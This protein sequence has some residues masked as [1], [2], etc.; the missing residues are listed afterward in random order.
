MHNTIKQTF[1]VKYLF[2]MVYLLCN[3]H[4]HRTLQ[5]YIQS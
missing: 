2:T 4:S 1:D 5:V 3:K